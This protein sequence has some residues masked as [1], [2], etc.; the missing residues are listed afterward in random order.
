MVYNVDIQTAIAHELIE[1]TNYAEE[2]LRSIALGT[3]TLA[4]RRMRVG[5]G[6]RMNARSIPLVRP[7]TVV[8][9][10]LHFLHRLDCCP[11]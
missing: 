7:G 5:R 3:I 1:Q 4:E 10:P 2:E 9:S 6:D 11:V 8:F